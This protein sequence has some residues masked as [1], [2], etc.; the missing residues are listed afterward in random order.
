[1]DLATI[2]G[3]IGG[4]GMIIM[5]MIVGGDPVVYYNLPSILIVVIG[6]LF[7]TMQKFTLEQFLGAFKI[8]GKAYAYKSVSQEEIIEEV[9]GLADAA[10]KGGL[11][12]PMKPSRDEPRIGGW[13]S[14]YSGTI[15]T[16]KAKS[17]LWM[18]R[19]SR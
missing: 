18:S 11:L 17:F 6:S 8:A 19:E 1:M 13:K 3:L 14:S 5:A 4:I 7:V 16:L 10:R 15:R 12:Q 9:V 2:V